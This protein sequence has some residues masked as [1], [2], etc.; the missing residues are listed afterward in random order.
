MWDVLEIKIEANV[1]QYK[2]TQNALPISFKKWIDEI[3]QSEEF[4]SFFVKILQESP[5]AAFFWEVKPTHAHQIETDFEFVLLNAPMLAKLRADTHSF[6]S[7]FT[8][9]DS[10]ATFSNLGGDARLIVPAQ[11]TECANYVHLAVFVRQAP[12]TQVFDLWK[13]TGQEYE[14]MINTDEKIKWLST[15]GLGVHW[16]HIRIDSFPKYYQYQPYKSLT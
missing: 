1:C 8:S 10:I 7:Y 15:S 12:D 9:S 5:Y 6:Q 4:V 14:R 3:Q 2:I 13:R 16:L 11:I